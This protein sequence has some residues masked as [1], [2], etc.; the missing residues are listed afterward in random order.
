MCIAAVVLMSSLWSCAD[1]LSTSPVAPTEEVLH[2][3]VLSPNVLTMAVGDT[4]RITATPR[5]ILGDTLPVDPS[6][7]V[8]WSTLD[9]DIVSV[10]ANGVITARASNDNFVN[11]T[12]TWHHGGVTRSATVSINVTAI[13]YSVAHFA[14]IPRDSARAGVGFPMFVPMT[15][16]EIG[17]VDAEGE[18]SLAPAVG[19]EFHDTL[20]QMI[21]NGFGGVNLQYESVGRYSISTWGSERTYGKFWVIAYA[22]MYG[23]PVR[24]SIAFVG[25]Y[26]TDVSIEITQ[27][28]VTGVL[29]S[30][31]QGGS[32]QLQPCAF[33]SFVNSSQTPLDIVFDD[34]SQAK[35]CTTADDTSKGNILG[36]GY[37]EGGI[38]QF[39]VVGT[40]TWSARNATTGAVIPRINGTLVFREP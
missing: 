20:G 22:T 17:T 29:T 28:P 15:Y 31:M 18:S 12:A 25:L 3:I 19:F 8:Q 39:P 14:L 24:D 30:S 6:E 27:D 1:A 34:P 32:A 7:P 4:M 21:P 38:R 23:V 16:L 26:S 13:R 9:N 5:N 36:I 35:G 11:V 10:D 33:V 40:R 37:G 2:E